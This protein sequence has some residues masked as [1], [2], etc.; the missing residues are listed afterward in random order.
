MCKISIITPSLNQA[1]YLEQTIDSVLSQKYANLEYIIIDGGSTDGSVEIIKKYENHLNYWVTKKDNGQSQAINKGVIRASG[2]IINWLNSD[3]YYK[4]DALKIVA[5]AF[6]DPAVNCFCGRSNLFNEDGFQRQSKRTDIYANGLAKN[7]GWARI[8][9]PET[10]FR[11][12]AWQRVGFLNE[13]LH[14]TMDREWWMRYLYHFGLSG[15]AKTDDVLVNFRL[16]DDSKTVSASSKFEEEHNTLFYLLAIATKN[17]GLQEL[18]VDFN[19][20]NLNLHSDLEKWSNQEIVQ[21]SLNYYLLKKAD[22]FYYNNAP[23]ASKAYLSA[24]KLEWLNIED[25]KLYYNLKIKTRL[26]LSVVHLFRK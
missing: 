26:P 16:H 6:G 2:E 9:Q 5:E 18:I 3:D 10:F 24:I 15:I 25:M 22:E 12:V 7:I 8:D 11:K 14:Y 17:L 23:E 20:I 21:K 13:H 1:Q 19:K 4:P